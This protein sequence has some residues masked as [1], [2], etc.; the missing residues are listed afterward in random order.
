MA[1]IAG[2]RDYARDVYRRAT[3]ASIKA[4][5]HYSSNRAKRKG[6]D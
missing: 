3:K 5:V 6:T 4:G 1:S 2:K